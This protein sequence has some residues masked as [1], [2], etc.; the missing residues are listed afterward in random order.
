MSHALAYDGEVIPLPLELSRG[1]IDAVDQNSSAASKAS[2]TA[3]LD[4]TVTVM[5]YPEDKNSLFNLLHEYRKVIPLPRESLGATG[6]AEHHIKSK[7]E[8]KPVKPETKPVHI[9]AYRLTHSQGQIVGE[10]IKD[11]LK[12]GVIQPSQSP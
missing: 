3:S 1:C 8:T 2:E 10:Q 6:K 9:P 12:Q 4:S 7:P 5:D 11:M